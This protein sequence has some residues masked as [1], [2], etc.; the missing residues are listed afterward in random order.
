MFE[1]VL[2]STC[3]L[4]W[5][6]GPVTATVCP[7]L[8]FDSVAS[9]EMILFQAWDKN[10]DGHISKVEFRQGARESFGL[11]FDNKDLDAYFASMDKGGAGTINVQ[12]LTSAL[13]GLL[14]HHYARGRVCAALRLAAQ[15]GGAA[16][17]KEQRGKLDS[18]HSRAQN[19]T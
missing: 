4:Q 13:N 3:T 15:L 18:W 17:G 10:H 5:A 12:Q 6:Y 19:F 9:Q 7:L 11:N 1:H 8:G 2:D 14:K 16:F